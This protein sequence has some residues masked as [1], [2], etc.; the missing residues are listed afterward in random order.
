MQR[1]LHM[2]L[3]VVCQTRLWKMLDSLNDKR[4]PYLVYDSDPN[5]ELFLLDPFTSN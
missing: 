1:S 5:C 2:Q 3:V 4:G